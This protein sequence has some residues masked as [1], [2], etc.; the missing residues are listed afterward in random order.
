MVRLAL[1]GAL[2]AAAKYQ[3]IVPRLVGA[4][5]TAV[6]ES[7]LE[8]ARRLAKS[9]DAPAWSTGLD[10]LL[11]HHAGV[12]DALIVHDAVGAIEDECRRA[13]DMGKHLLVSAPQLDSPGLLEIGNAAEQAKLRFMW[14]PPVRHLP[15]VKIMKESL[16]SGKMGEL[17]LVRMHHW[18]PSAVRCLLPA[19][20]LVCSLFNQAPSV[21]YATCGK[22]ATPTLAMSDYVQLHLGFPGCGMAVLD[23]ARTGPHSDGY[24]S[25]SLIGST[26]AAYADDHHDMQLLYNEGHPAALKTDQGDRPLLTQLQEFV[27]AIVDARA[28]QPGAVEARRAFEV[29][30]AAEKSLATRRAIQLAAKSQ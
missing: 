30:Q 14:G 27:A 16:A 15:A 23:S 20:D 17:G 22:P 7:D 9:V 29:A 25:L 21:V 26:G 10:D 3:R 28:P 13:V 24:F 12:F 6:V 8:A 18:E 1:I 19:I 5:I 11:L 2:D 4:R